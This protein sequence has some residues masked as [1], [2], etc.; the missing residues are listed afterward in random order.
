MA[1]EHSLDPSPAA[2]GVLAAAPTPAQATSPSGAE[3]LRVR[4]RE[5]LRMLPVVAISYVVDTGLLL[6]FCVVGVLPWTMPLVFLASG[7][8][9]CAL[10]HV[11][12][13]SHFP[14]RLRDHHMVMEQMAA[15]CALLMTFLVWTPQVGVPLMLL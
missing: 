8:V 6:C 4:R 12:L 14:E 3:A 2:A 7:L 13:S 10:F 11:V 9:V 15:H 5:R 1:S